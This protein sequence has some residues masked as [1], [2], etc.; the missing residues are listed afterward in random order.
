MEPVKRI[1]G[2]SANI[3]RSDPPVIRVVLME[4]A[5]KNHDVTKYQIKAN[6]LVNGAPWYYFTR[7]F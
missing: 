6:P 1:W 2:V 3:R 5:P 7:Y 4:Q